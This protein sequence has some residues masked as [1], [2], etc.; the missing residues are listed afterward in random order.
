MLYMKKKLYLITDHYPF[1]HG[2]IPFINSELPFLINEFNVTIISKDTVENLT[3]SLPQDIAILR[4]DNNIPIY[5]KLKY[6]IKI[7]F[8]TAFYFELFNI[9]GFASKKISAIKA[10]I[11]F[12]ISANAFTSFLYQNKVFNESNSIFY[13]YWSNYATL[14]LVR[15]KKNHSGIKVITR[16]HGYD[17]FDNRTPYNYQFFKKY[18]HRRLDRVI[19]ASQN[20]K[21]YYLKRYSLKDCNRYC[22]HRLGS[23]NSFGMAKA[24]HDGKLKILSCSNVIPLKRI[25]LIIEGLALLSRFEIIW[26]HIGDGIEFANI[27]K[28]AAEKLMNKTKVHYSLRGYMSNDAIH[29]FLQNNPVDVFITTSST[30]GGC[31]V[32]ISEAMSYGIPVIGTSVGGIT[33]MIKDVG[34]LLSS[35]PSSLEIASSL[36]QMYN[37]KIEDKNRIRQKTRFKWEKA[38]NANNNS[39]RF[40]EMLCKSDI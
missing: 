13:S 24:V 1:G 5:L 8:D 34:L 28:L 40:L 14:A 17:L 3:S 7:I 22:L 27:K 26:T 37:M 29:S 21:D 36:E 4:Y 35:N 15:A 11:N 10:M 33:E 18:M 32:S 12:F 25:E 2:E 38:F 20:A 31:P 19:F 30:E 23:I 9:I 39:N 6:S 16:L